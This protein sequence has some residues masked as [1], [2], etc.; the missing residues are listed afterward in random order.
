LKLTCV[1]RYSFPLLLAT[2]ALLAQQAAV[3][4]QDLV[5]VQPPA[6]SSDAYVQLTLGQNYLWSMHEM[7]NPVPLLVIAAKAGI[8]H[9][10]NNPSRWGQG[11]EGYATRAASHFGRSFLRENIAFGIRAVDHEDPRYFRAH[12]KGAWKRTGYAASRT[13][14][15]RSERGGNMPAYST[16]VADFATPFIAQT[17]RPEPISAGRELRSGVMG[18][19]INAVSNV[20]QEFWPD[21][22]RML[23]RH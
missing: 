10:D 15:A 14:V 22:R 21:I 23:Q 3:V 19:G 7:F 18:I 17:W 12:S 9:S 2:T 16:L 1:A 13:F 20:G 8:D 4:E 5:S 11:M 6:A